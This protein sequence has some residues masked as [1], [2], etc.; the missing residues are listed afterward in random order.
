MLRCA[1]YAFWM[2]HDT[3]RSRRADLSPGCVSL[4]SREETW[5]SLSGR[6]LEGLSTGF[7]CWMLPSHL[8]GA[9]VSRILGDLGADVIKIEPPGGDP[10][11]QMV[12]LLPVGA[13]QL[14]DFS[15]RI[16]LFRMLIP[17]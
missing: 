15:K 9:Y 13:E 17:D 1:G 7:T 10:G 12:P 3:G 14:G 6:G 4:A 2:M 16:S 8:D 5:K 11:R